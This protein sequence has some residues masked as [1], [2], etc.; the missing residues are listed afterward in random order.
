MEPDIASYTYVF[1]GDDN[2]IVR[3]IMN[4]KTGD[5]ERL[6]E[7]ERPGGPAPL[8]INLTHTSLYVRQLGEFGMSSFA[9]NQ[10]PRDVTPP[11]KT[12]E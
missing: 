11:W 5:L 9:I 4:P 6:S 2:R 10:H 7:I 8:I 3:F 1:L 12:T